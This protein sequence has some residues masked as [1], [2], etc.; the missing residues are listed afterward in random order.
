MVRFFWLV[1]WSKEGIVLNRLYD[2][3]EDLGSFTIFGSE[4]KPIAAIWDFCFT[5]CTVGG[6]QYVLICLVTGIW[7]S[8]KEAISVGQPF[9]PGPFPGPFKSATT[10]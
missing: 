5:V 7:V 4:Y 10:Q 8:S 1:T 2:D 3:V 6:F 9:R